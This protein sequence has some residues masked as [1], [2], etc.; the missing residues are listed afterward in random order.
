MTRPSRLHNVFGA[1]ASLFTVDSE[2]H[3]LILTDDDLHD[4][5]TTRG[6]SMRGASTSAGSFKAKGA[7]PP[8][9]SSRSQELRI[10][11]TQHAVDRF[12]A[13]GVTVPANGRRRFTGRA[14]GQATDEHSDTK[15]TTTV[16]FQDWLALAIQLDKG[17]MAYRTAPQLSNL[18]AD[19]F[20]RA[21]FE[22][23]VPNIE[24]WGSS[25]PHYRFEDADPNGVLISSSDVVG[26]Y[27]ADVGIF[28]RSNRNARPI[29]YSH[30]HTVH[31]AEEW[32]FY[33]PD[34]L[35][36]RQVLA[37]V[38]WVQPSAIPTSIS[39]SKITSAGWEFGGTITVGGNR[40]YAIKAQDVDLTHVI[41]QGDGFYD[42]IR[43]LVLQDSPDRPRVEN[44][45]ISLLALLERG[46]E[47][48]RALVRQ[49]LLLEHGD[50]V[51]FGHDWPNG[52]A[53]VYFAAQIKE[54]ITPNSW[55]FEL[56][57]IP[58]NHVTGRLIPP[59]SGRTWNSAYPA[60]TQWDDPATA[61]WDT[62]P[63][64]A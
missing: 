60:I 59:V 62:V 18:L 34:T 12:A 28:I 11:L 20:V 64:E 9:S 63:Q 31:L 41:E 57:L 50:V 8:L 61:T 14:A 29:I 33:W 7:L 4:I 47:S 24:T 53:S 6:T 40:G 44:V 21:G 15:R 48:D 3:N 51:T 45:T 42:F 54:R 13:L 37:P 25:W 43:S 35:L 38:Q 36:R 10:E 19:F 39:Y 58:A 26:K 32:A 22:F 30:D 2:S 55:T 17:G 1:T 46:D 23:E 27:A 16:D 49:L 52:L 56:G 5:S